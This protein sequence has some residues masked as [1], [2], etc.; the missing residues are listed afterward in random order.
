MNVCIWLGPRDA[1]LNA[2]L[3]A[4]GNRYKSLMIGKAIEYY[5]DTG[6]YLCIGAVNPLSADIKS[7]H[8][9]IVVPAK[10]RAEE[11]YKEISSQAGSLA[12]RQLKGLLQNCIMYSDGENWIPEPY[13]RLREIE[14][15]QTQG[16]DVA[17]V[18]SEKT[19]IKKDEEKTDIDGAEKEEPFATE[20]QQDKAKSENTSAWFDKLIDDF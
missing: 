6:R 13:E 14:N 20:P 8:T 11:W 19:F 12:S 9:S 5:L 4:P 10:T 2:W 16:H 1:L 18:I 3:K 17:P 7:K 15:G